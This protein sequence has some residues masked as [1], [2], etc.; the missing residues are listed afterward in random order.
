MSVFT[1]GTAQ[2]PLTEVEI[3][4]SCRSLQRKDVL[5][6]SDPMVVVYIQPFGEKIWKEKCRTEAIENCHDPDFMRK[7]II[8]YHF[9]EEQHLMFR[10]YDIDS[11]SAE[12]TKHDFL[13]VAV[14][15]LGQIIS[16]GKV[17][18]PLS[19]D[20]VTCAE[21]NCG[22]I[23][24]SVE[25]LA[26]VR[27][28]VILQFQGENLDR[29]DIFWKSDPFLVIMKAMEN[30]DFNVVCKTEVVKLTLDP[31]W[32]KM[33]IPVRILCNGDFER[34]LKVVCYDWNRN[35]KNSLIG[36]FET[37]L[38]ILSEGPGF[39]N[40]YT[41][42]NKEKRERKSNYQNSGKV[43]LIYYE[44]QTL[45]SF[46][47]YIIGG[48]EIHCSFAIDFTSSNGDPSLRSSLHY[49]SSTLNSYEIAIQAVGTIIQDYASDREFPVLGFGARLPPDG[50]VSHEFFVNM[51]TD[52]PYCKG[53]NG[54]YLSVLEAYHSCIRKVQLYG[55]T[56]FCPVINLVARFASVYRDGAHYFVLLII[57]DGVITDMQKTVEAIVCA[58]CLPL[59][60][61]IVG[62]GEADFTA[63]EDLDSDTM[64]LTA[65]DGTRAV[66]DIVQFVPMRNFLQPGVD[67]QVARIKLAK[68]VL[69]EI[70]AQFL[71]YMR[72]NRIVPRQTAPAEETAEPIPLPPDPELL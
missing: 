14:C 1:P 4:I 16:K 17:Q 9:E 68:E 20:E 13:G 52:H 55:P 24:L 53:I 51:R 11:E 71:S 40:M 61:I 50:R 44:L 57:T 22:S 46:M 12:L 67:P 42:I 63:M 47:D 35:G 70:P 28:N 6:K 5:S 15:T 66:R 60:I 2:S 48:T 34:T 31:Y 8:A 10:V 18:I 41:L 62:V 21:G 29:K 38:K 39:K 37:N 58:S 56:N 65:T 69:A 26:S 30:G 49:I 64:P 36:E 43:S 72:P 54:K 27:D 25:E 19:M 33:S 59:S 3:T 23:I 32:R 7:V 45:Y